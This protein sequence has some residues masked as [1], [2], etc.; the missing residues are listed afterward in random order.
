[1][2][3]QHQNP[4]F[5]IQ[6]NLPKSVLVLKRVRGTQKSTM[7][8]LWQ[9]EFHSVLTP[10]SLSATIAATYN[11]TAPT[12]TTTITTLEPCADLIKFPYIV[13]LSQRGDRG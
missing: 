2:K 13:D 5:E 10:F 1:M 11:F 9:T 12:C 4:E 6:K 3:T 7:F 8:F